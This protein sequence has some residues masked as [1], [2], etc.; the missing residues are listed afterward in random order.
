M[1]SPRRGISRCE[2]PPPTFSKYF[3]VFRNWWRQ[4]SMEMSRVHVISQQILMKYLA[5]AGPLPGLGDSVISD[6]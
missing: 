1:E 6:I 4:E 2:V 3:N 5:C